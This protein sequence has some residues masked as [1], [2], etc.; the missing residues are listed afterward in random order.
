M[1]SPP[2]TPAGTDPSENVAGKAVRAELPERLRVDHDP[3][4]ITPQASS[5]EASPPRVGRPRNNRSAADGKG[6]ESNAAADDDD[7]TLSAHRKGMF[8]LGPSG[9]SGPSSRD[10]SPS[11]NAASQYY[12]RPLTPAGDR[13]DPYAADKRPPQPSNP[14]PTS[15]ESRF[16]F[17][18]GKGSSSSGTTPRISLDRS[19]KRHSGILGSLVKP[20]HSH[21]Q[22]HPDDGAS[23]RPGSSVSLRRFFKVGASKAER[24]VS[25]A[26]VSPQRS[27]KTPPSSKSGHQVPF[28]DDHGL[29]SKYGRL[30]KVL[31][32]GAGGSV[33]LMR[34]AEDNTVFAVKEFRPQHSYETEKDYV[35][36]LTA[37]F[38]IG[39]TLHHGNVIETLDIVHEKGKWFEVMEYA[40]YDLF[41]IV[42][43]GR[44]S[45]EEIRCC[46]LQILSGVTYLH[47]MGLAHRDLKL[48]NVVVGEHGIMKII[49]FGSA[50]VFKYPF[51]NNIHLATGRSPS[52]SFPPPFSFSFFFLFFLSR[53]VSRFRRIRRI[54]SPLTAPPKASSDLIRI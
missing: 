20:Q 30:G 50:H 8:S 13:N 44:M 32:A 9:S 35:K 16:V 2:L 6:A 5:H 45:R 52:P 33:R 24:P 41:A 21:E 48:D 46:F 18:R 38:C 19:E 7:G 53:R 15:I 17:K 54:T 37:E 25:P 10:V 4:A 47:S 12:T 51:E 26:P 42:M 1:Q 29:S 27:V 14:S 39:S 22:L 31:G 3:R 34:R 28:A 49:D 11:R 43:T 23:S 36:K 40:P